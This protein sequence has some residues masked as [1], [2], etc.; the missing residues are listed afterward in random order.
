VSTVYDHVS[1]AATAT[2]LFGLD[3]I[4]ERVNETS[5]FRDCIHP[6]FIGNPQAAPELP[7][8]EIS[9][10]ALRALPQTPRHLELAKA[11][12]SMNLPSRLHRKAESLTIAERVMRYGEKLGAVKL[13]R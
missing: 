13:T 10:S 11:I 12:A 5:D 3:P 7:P 8:V 9:M 6:D 4:R 1:V 2:R